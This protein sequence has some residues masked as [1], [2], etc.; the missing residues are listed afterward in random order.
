MSKSNNKNLLYLIQQAGALMQTFRSHKRHLKTSFD[1]IASH[2][3][4]VAIMSYCIAKTEGLSEEDARKATML[5]I[6]HDLP[7]ARTGD[8]DFVSKNYTKTDETKAVKD[9]LKNLDFGKELIELF[10]E[11]DKKETKI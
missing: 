8:L 3:Y 5:A 11:Y 9:Q 1:T 4:L 10:E 2:S 6:V 7:E